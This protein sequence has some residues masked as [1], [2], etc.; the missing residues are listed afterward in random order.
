[1]N[2][3]DLHLIIGLGKTGFS[4][5]EYLRKKDLNVAVLDSRQE[6]PYLEKTKSHYPEVPLYLGGWQHAVWEQATEIIASPGV[7]LSELPKT[8]IQPIGDIELFAREAHAPI[9][10][11]TGANGKTTVTNV[12]TEMAKE[13][14]KKVQ[15]GGN[16]GTPALELLNAS[17]TELFVLELSSFQLESTNSLRPTVATVLNVTPDHLDRHGG[18]QAYITAKQRIYNNSEI[19]VFNRADKNTVPPSPQPTP[20]SGRGSNSWSF[21]LDKPKNANEFG[22]SQGFLVRGNDHLIAIQD[23]KRQESHNLENALAAL[24]MGYAVGLPLAAMVKVL[25]SFEGLPHRCQVVG[26]GKGIE[27]VNDSKATNVGAAIAAIESLG[28]TSK[29]VLIAGGESKASDFSD[30]ARAVKNHVRGVVLIGRDKQ[31]LADA[32]AGSV[33]V[34]FAESMQQAVKEAEKIAKSGDTVLLSPACA[35]FDM[36]NNYAHRGEVFTQT[37]RREILC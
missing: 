12:L 2:K 10:A 8:R 19:A 1:M 7:S 9:A 30:F 35:S 33:P 34:S 28:K 15:M 21:G 3:K 29:L 13:A 32:L 23:L 24:A 37:V 14:S 11:I 22:I 31:L 4:C 36:F 5:V 6:P 25:Q 17:D 26:T 27:W 20:A 18:M 16:V